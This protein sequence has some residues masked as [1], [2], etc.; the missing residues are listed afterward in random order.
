MVEMA[1]MAYQAPL[2]RMERM[3]EMAGMVK[4]ERLE[5][6]GSLASKVYLDLP[7]QAVEEW[8]TLAGD[9][10]PALT[11]QEQSL[12]MQERLEGLTIM[13]ME[14]QPTTSA[15]QRTQTI[16][17]TRLECKALVPS[18]GLS[19]SLLEVLLLLLVNMTYLA[20]CVILQPERR[21]S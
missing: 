15:C 8:F 7:A 12:S 20:Q 14:E 2:A 19:T 16:Y 9:E 11:L 5:R 13:H 1:T 6:G 3:A 18:M 10:Q 4:M 17:S 21:L